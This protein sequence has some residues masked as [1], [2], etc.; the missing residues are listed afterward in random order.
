M[1]RDREADADDDRAA[2]P[3]QDLLQRHPAVLGQQR[4][5][6]PQRLG[7]LA[8]RRDQ[9][10]LDARTASAITSQRA[11][12]SQAPSSATRI[13]AGAARSYRRPT[14]S[15]GHRY[16]PPVTAAAPL[17]S[18]S[19]CSARSRSDVKSGAVT[20]SRRGGCARRGEG[21]SATTVAGRDDSAATRSAEIQG[22]LHVVGDQDRRAR[23][24]GERLGQPFLHLGAGDRVQ[25]RERLVQEEHRL[26]GQQGTEEGDSL[27]HPAREL[28]RARALEAGQPESLEQRM[29]RAASLGARGAAI[30]KRQR[31]VV[32]RGQPGKQEVALGHVRA[33]GQPLG[34]AGRPLHL[35]RA[36]T[37]PPADRRPAPAESTCRTRK[38]Q[39]R[40][41]RGRARRP[42]PAA[43]SLGP[44]RRSGEGSGL[45]THPSSASRDRPDGLRAPLARRLS[46]PMEALLREPRKSF[47]CSLR[48]H[49]RDRF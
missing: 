27:A 23:L 1:Q 19:A 25:R 43:R 10:R 34:G 40:R 28:R 32:D 41:A 42:S 6:L 33:A 14:R 46:E 39:R 18:P 35:D 37:R 47:A 22:L 3:E 17:P 30:A 45:S 26:A 16:R 29:C 49:Y 5:V 12:S 8:R 31:G 13:A 44:G 15:A 24:C 7:D 38:G 11:A 9:E 21:R 2:E 4:A 20:V 48:A 36:G